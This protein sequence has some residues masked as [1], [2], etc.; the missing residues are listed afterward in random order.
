MVMIL[1]HPKTEV[2]QF[3]CGNYLFPCSAG[4]VLFP[5]ESFLLN[6]LD[7]CNVCR[8]LPQ[9]AVLDCLPSTCTLAQ[10]WFGKSYIAQNRAARLHDELQED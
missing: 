6:L 10:L 4:L 9:N 5:S 2:R 8:V 3:D 7:Y 1:N